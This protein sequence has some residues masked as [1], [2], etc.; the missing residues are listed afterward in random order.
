[1]N[2]KG[3]TGVVW[4]GE[5]VYTAHIGQLRTE[6]TMQANQ[7]RWLEFKGHHQTSPLISD[8]VT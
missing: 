5:G 4:P 6:G 3:G 1:M 2:G 8:C 7:W